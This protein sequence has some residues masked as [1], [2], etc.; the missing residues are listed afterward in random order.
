M[1]D[2]AP[3]Y[4]F[5][6]DSVYAIHDGRVIASGKKDD[7]G[8]VESDATKYLDGLKNEKDERKK[9]SATHIVSPNG[10]K[11]KLLQRTATVWGDE[12][13]VRWENGEV[14]SY[15]AHGVKEWITERI[16]STEGPVK[17]LDQ[18]LGTTYEHDRNSLVKRLQDLRIIASEA[19]ELL[20]VGAAYADEMALD[21][22]VVTA[23]AE[24][25]GVRQAIDHIDSD[26][27]DP[28]QP[29]TPQAMPQ[30]DM[31]RA[32]SWIDAVVQDMV[33]ESDKNDFEQVLNDE[34]VLLAAGLDDEVLYDQGAS[35][36]IAFSHVA[37][38]TAGYV[39][40][41][42]EAYHD[43]FLA[44]F[45]MARRKELE[46]RT[47]NTRKEAAVVESRVEDTPD[48]ALFG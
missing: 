40:D 42:V 11:G 23:D 29:P 43:Q 1:A 39:G 38:K 36:E 13:T 17:A 15:P 37:D 8:D 44:R 26:A 34:P 48:E 20:S 22:I 31:G 19:R 28:Y 7:V 33:S 24:A 4:H 14:K 5:E 16:A 2:L 32:D 18:R 47:V 21:T 41:D 35:R 3:T 27:Y 30:A 6:G 10:L 25:E 45:E 12:I 46:S 9:K